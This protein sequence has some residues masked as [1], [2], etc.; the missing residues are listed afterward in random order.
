MTAAGV[1]R[2]YDG[3]T[4]ATVTL[5]TDKI[6]SDAVDASY[7]AAI[8][9]DKH[10]GTGK[11]VSVTGISIAGPD[12]GNYALANTTATTTADISPRTLTVTATG[13]SRVYDGTLAASVT[14]GDDRIAADALTL[15]YAS[16]AFAD[17]NA[18]I[19]KT[20][21]VSGI[22]IAGGADAHRP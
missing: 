18:G 6:G 13:V 10:V 11:T 9:A 19:A 2:P 8:F 22:G 4:T 15:S 17:K 16:A 1:S 3:T 21:T 12:A 14:L 7:A 5:G 20:V